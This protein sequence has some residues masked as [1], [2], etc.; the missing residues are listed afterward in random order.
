MGIALRRRRRLFFGAGFG[1]ALF[2]AN[3][4]ARGAEQPLLH[5]IALGPDPKEL[6]ATIQ[7]LVGFGTRHSLSD[8]ASTK[9]GIGASRR[10]V[11]TRFEQIG[12]DCGG[13][14]SV[15]T[16][17]QTFTGPRVPTPTAIVDVVAIQT[18][19]TDPDRV[20]ILTAHIDSRVTDPLNAKSDAPGADDDASGVALVIETA[21]IADRN[22]KR[23]SG[24]RLPTTLLERNQP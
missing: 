4:W 9:R 5:E 23:P 14:L 1:L 6:Q 24:P 18:G 22:F 7:S 13:C 19:T 21:R 15:L 16:P 10:W 2:F 12:R 17:S 8:T 11:Q 3:P 20:I